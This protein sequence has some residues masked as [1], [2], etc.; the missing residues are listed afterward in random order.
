VPYNSHDPM[1]TL[2]RYVIREVIGPFLIGLLVFTFVLIIPFI[3]ELAET[4]IA[5]GVPWQTLLVL[6]ATLLPQALGLTIPMALLI[7]LL[8]AF[9]RLSGDREVVA[10]MACGVSPFRLLRPLAVLAGATWLATSW[11]LLYAIPD[12][13]QAYREITMRLVADRAEGEVRPRVFFED[14]PNMV[15]YVGDVPPTGGWRDVMAADTRDPNQPVLY[16]ARSGRMLVDRAQRTIQMVLED[17]TQHTTRSDEPADYKVLRFERILVSLDPE[18]VFP[19]NGPARGDRE[20]TIAELQQRADDLVR[21]NDSP[22]NPLME[23]H[24]KFSI[25]AACWVFAVIG[26]AL[27]ATNRR[28]G[29][30]ASFVLGIGVILVYYVLMYL[31]QSLAKGHFLSPWLAMWLPNLVLGAVGAV[32]LYRRAYSAD[33]PIRIS[34]PARAVPAWLLPRLRRLMPVASAQAGAPATA[35]GEAAA[36]ADAPQSVVLVLRIPDLDIPR[37]GILD[38][39]VAGVYLRVLGL[40]V[41]GMAG[42]FYISTFIDLSDKLFKGTATLGM[43]LEYFWWATPQFLYYIVAIAVLLAALVTIGLLTKNSELIVMRACGVSL[44]RTAVP[45]LA[46]A[47]LASGVLF[48]LEDRVMAAANRRADALRH[49]IRGGSPQTFDVLNRKWL[50]GRDGTIY[51]YQ[52]FDPRRQELNG[53]TVIR[54]DASSGAI[55][56]RAYARVATFDPVL[57][58]SGEPAWVADQGWIRDF[59]TDGNVS[60]FETFGKLRFPFEPAGYFVTEAPEPR[61]MNFA[62]LR[63]YVD[64]LR[65]SGYDVRKYQVDLQRKIAFPFVTLIMTLIAVPFAVTTGR[66]GAMYGIGI[67]IVIALSYW[68]LISVFAAFGAGGL[69]SP[70]LAAWAPNLLF[71][72]AAIY[73]LLTVRT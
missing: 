21:N 35:H 3:I 47:L 58:S 59:T 45:L 36:A 54:M 24:K 64:E 41:A 50:V 42:L 26:L 9:G 8:V 46:C 63:Q 32:L 53:L 20:L 12:A 66:R 65:G 34:L 2:D 30:L 16:L 44:Y 14:F 19:R 69:I 25:P 7:A 15:L 5:K 60:R 18:S 70:T 61:R 31:G 56:R 4:L 68:T 13:N 62:Q 17:G 33:Q 39:Y 49:V 37:P 55:L 22:H 51:H 67:G 71:G 57:A 52:F 6:M 27:G 28:D 11:V 29:K 40:S 38:M 1:R 43:L 23:I 73:L 72:A 48:A 10:M